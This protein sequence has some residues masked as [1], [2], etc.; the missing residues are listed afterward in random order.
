[1]TFIKI[2]GYSD[3]FETS[4]DNIAACL[5]TGFKDLLRQIGKSPSYIANEMPLVLQQTFFSSVAYITW[6]HSCVFE[7]QL[8]FP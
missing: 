4:I 8:D 2:L 6:W 5:F 3:Y 7:A 1:M